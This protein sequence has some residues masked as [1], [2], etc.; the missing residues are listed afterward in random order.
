MYSLSN[1]SL[2]KLFIQ[3]CW[4]L[5]L[6]WFHMT[7]TEHFHKLHDL[8]ETNYKLKQIKGPMSDKATTT[9]LS[10]SWL[11]VSFVQA[12]GLQFSGNSLFFG[13]LKTFYYKIATD[14]VK[15]GH[16]HR[17]QCLIS[18]IINMCDVNVHKMNVIDINVSLY[19][20]SYLWPPPLLQLAYP[21][22]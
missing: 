21:A 9:M 22:T 10:W 17:I 11:Y 3:C 20:Y 13:G 14:I 16:W 12:M 15:S 1:Q 19:A 8:A 7:N 5:I 2:E 4:N 6:A 18:W